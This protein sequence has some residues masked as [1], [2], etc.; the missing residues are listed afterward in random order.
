[1][2]TKRVFVSSAQKAAARAMVN[3][4]A[5]TGRKISNSVRKI[6]DAKVESADDE[7]AKSGVGHQRTSA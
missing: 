7:L 4:S 5:V 6:A 2:M 1:M 3:R